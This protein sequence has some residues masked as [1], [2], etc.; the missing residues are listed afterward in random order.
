MSPEALINPVALKLPVLLA[1]IPWLKKVL[2]MP[3][4]AAKHTESPMF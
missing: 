3:S 2:V 1:A 4:G